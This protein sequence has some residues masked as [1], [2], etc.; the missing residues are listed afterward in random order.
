MSSESSAHFPCTVALAAVSST[1]EHSGWRRLEHNAARVKKY[2]SGAFCSQNLKCVDVLIFRVHMGS[3]EIAGTAY[4]R[5][6]NIYQYMI[7]VCVMY[8]FIHK[9]LFKVSCDIQ[10]MRSDHAHSKQMLWCISVEK[11]QYSTPLTPATAGSWHLCHKYMRNVAVRLPVMEIS[12]NCCPKNVASSERSWERLE[13]ADTK[14]RW[15]EKFWESFVSCAKRNSLLP[16]PFKSA[17]MCCHVVSTV[18][19]FVLY[20]HVLYIQKVACPERKIFR[21]FCRDFWTCSIHFNT[22]KGAWLSRCLMASWQ[23]PRCH[24]LAVASTPSQWSNSSA[25]WNRNRLNYWATINL[26]IND[27]KCA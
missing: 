26:C 12:C 1:G 13:L 22:T 27:H 16:W 24:P 2:P 18:L 21:D 15:F 9:T 7:C 17:D 3:H 8:T 10:D 6:H 4:S 20:I 25:K 23:A 19:Q 14:I 5:I 11:R